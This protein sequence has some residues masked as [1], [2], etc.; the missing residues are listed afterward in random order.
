MALLEAV[1]K[2]NV[3]TGVAVGLS[4]FLLGPTVGQALRP[5][6]KMVIKGGI[7]AYQG[8]AE[9]GE[10]ASDLIAEARVEFEQQGQTEDAPLSPPAGRRTRPARD[11]S[12]T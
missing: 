7:L 11:P 8:L 3:L 2:G 12:E 9:L 5:A 4:T 10:A 1:F 6:A